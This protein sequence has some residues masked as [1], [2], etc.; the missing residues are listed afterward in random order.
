MG[1][2]EP[3]IINI[4]YEYTTSTLSDESH[5][6]AHWSHLIRCLILCSPM[7]QTPPGEW[8]LKH[9]CANEEQLFA[10]ST[11]VMVVALTVEVNVDFPR[12]DALLCLF[13]I[14]CTPT[15]HRQTRLHQ[16]LHTIHTSHILIQH[17]EIHRIATPKH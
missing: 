11:D 8:T 3:V 17:E 14:F 7:H 5:S 1:T 6:V 15:L 4:Y 9:C 12:V 10:R 2:Q 16:T 13:V